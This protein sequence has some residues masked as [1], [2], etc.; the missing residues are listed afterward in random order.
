MIQVSRVD[1]DGRKIDFRLVQ[2]G[3]E[4]VGRAMLEKGVQREAIKHGVVS[5]RSKKSHAEMKRTREKSGAPPKQPE[6]STSAGKKTP[7][8]RR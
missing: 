6:R 1:L 5:E 7:R 2:E 8:K 4:L 3:G